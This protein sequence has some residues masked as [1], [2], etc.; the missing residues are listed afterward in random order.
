MNTEAPDITQPLYELLLKYPQGLSEHKLISVLKQPDVAIFSAG[1]D[2]SDSLC[3]FQTHFYLFNQLY[4]LR[5]QLRLSQRADL[6]I[7]AMSVCLRPYTP[8]C[9]ALSESDSLA[10]YYLDWSNFNS[11]GKEDVNALLDGFWQ[12]MGGIVPEQERCEALAVLDLPK[13]ASP[14]Q[15]RRQYRILVHRHHPDKG[16]D[17]S[18]TRKLNDAYRKLI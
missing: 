2:L 9:N 17:V 7:S 5:N 1:L 3:L 14:Q 16:G 10:A 12:R 11:T 18:K 6:V 13:D 8:G 4:R 15:I